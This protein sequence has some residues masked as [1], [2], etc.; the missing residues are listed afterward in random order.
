MLLTSLYF[1]VVARLRDVEIH[2]DDAG[3]ESAHFRHRVDEYM[4]DEDLDVLLADIKKTMVLNNT[5]SFRYFDLHFYLFGAAI[6]VLIVSRLI[7][8]VH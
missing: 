5:K 3:I 4:G 7:S 1:G 6:P 8:S 2:L